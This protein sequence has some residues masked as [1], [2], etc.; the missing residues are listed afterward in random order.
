MSSLAGIGLKVLSTFLFAIMIALIKQLSETV[1]TG[2]I[3]FSRCFF[4]LIPLLMMNLMQ[5]NLSDCI[6]T[7]HPMR[8][9]TR[10]VVGA[11]A[12]FSW[13]MALK[14][15]P[16][17]EATAISFAAPLMVVALAALFLGETVRLY[18]W[19]A[20]LLGC[21][22]V[23]IILW[24]RLMQSGD[25][26][27]QNDTAML[28]VWFA[29]SATCLMAVASILVRRM[30][31]T[32]R[33]SAIVFYFFVATSIFSL[34]SLYWGWVLP[35][36]TTLGLLV[37]AG[38]F[39]GVAQ[40]IMTQAFRLT[41]ASLLAPFDYV[42]MVWAIAIGAVLFDE[43]PSAQVMLGGAIVIAAGLLVV[44]RERQLRLRR[45]ERKVQPV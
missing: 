41:E 34:V 20:V 8:H 10:A 11:S 35:D 2:E 19:G 12:M 23:F 25:G 43:Y 29:I 4:A 28:G 39:G 42:N 24:P 33:N 7:D 14:Y 15:L 36:W 22:G 31:K 1:P 21:V 30:T 45:Q 6:R 37:L 9:A 17:P 40:I 44:F 26:A 13:F 5:G 38:I 27:E 16:L 18:R 32:E 3:V